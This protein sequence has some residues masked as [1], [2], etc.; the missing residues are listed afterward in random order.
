MASGILHDLVA[1]LGH[2]PAIELVRAWGGRRLK[3]PAVIH[4]D[5]ALVFIVG[6]DAAQLLAREYGG[7]DAMDLPAER[8]FLV[9]MRNDAILADFRR[10]RS[11]TWLSHTYGISRRQVNSVLDRMG[12]RADRLARADH[13]HAATRT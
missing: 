10:R 13:L 7:A 12:A 8:N 11:I 5:H 9:D 4:E 2:Q 1:L 6:W 3:V